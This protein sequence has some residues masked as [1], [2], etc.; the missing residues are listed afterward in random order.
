MASTLIVVESPAKVNTLKKYL[1]SGY[2][3]K[4]SVGHIKDLPKSK[5]GIDVDRDFEPT[6]IIKA[7]RKKTIAELKK[8][9]RS[10]RR[11]LLA[12]DPDREGEAI[13]WHVAEEIG[14]KDKDVY[15]I[16]FGDLTKKTVMEALK[17]PLPLDENKYEAQQTRRI[18]DR[19]VGYQISPVLWEKVRRG[20]SA[21]RVQSVAVR[22]ICERE[23][24]IENFVQE[25]YWS[26]TAR[27]E[28]PEPPFFEAKLKKVDG[29][30][31]PIATE[32]EAEDII[33]ELKKAVFVVNSVENNEVKRQPSPPFTTSK[34]QQEAAQ[35]LRFSAKKTMAV[36]QRLYEGI[37]LGSEGPVGLITYMRTDSVRV[38]DEALNEA[39][40]FISERYGKDYLPARARRHK[41][42]KAAQDAHEA[43]RPSSMRYHPD[44]VKQYLDR[45]EYR[46]YRLIWN[47]FIASQM[48]P[49][50]YDR[51]IVNITAGRYLFSVQGSVMKF[52]G[53]T[54][55]YG[56]SPETESRVG[57]DDNENNAAKADGNLPL[58]S[59][60]DTLTVLA[61]DRKQH[62]TQPPPRFTEASL[63]RELEESGIGRPS[64]YAAIL[65]TIQERNYVKLEDRRFRPT[66]LGRVVTD[67]LVE[68]F[69]GI[70][71]ISFT[72]SMEDKLDGIEEGTLKRVDIL[73]DFYRT[74]SSE[75]EKAKKSMKNM[76]K[77]EEA[78]E[79]E[80]ERCG[81]PMVIKWGKNGRFIACS[82]YPAC[83]NTA[84]IIR[85]DSGRVDRKESE[86]TDIRCEKCGKNMV[87]KEGRFG[88]F[89]GC[90]GYPECSYTRPIDTGVKCPRD[91]C[92]GFLC[93]RRSRRGRVFFGCSEYPDCTF[94]TWDRPLPESC[95]QCG[96]P[97]LV[98]KYSKSKGYFK[99]CPD[100]ECGYRLTLED[101]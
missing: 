37:E 55:V 14:G 64:T 27:L 66:E 10:A 44:T 94:A 35:R 56:D 17:N 77:E 60:G 29:K 101:L 95:P 98:L 91:G 69:P 83:K 65:S 53:F 88:K 51:T 28:G 6:Y 2:D 70:L 18:L 72:A 23:K 4:A 78:T 5:L 38:A 22:I 41:T 58:L 81:S 26:I 87:V 40:S 25:E 11:I 63:V 62:F 36:A 1:G 67:L 59:T 89:L 84:N 79:L 68:S 15:R 99:A 31:V 47:R 82:N 75:L 16:L 50:V 74:F 85:D 20:L 46:L 73:K 52:P 92:K 48:T 9:A 90:S 7:D 54:M 93:E 97:Y 57:G 33:E 45:D 13:A 49:A 43:I 100:R 24:E 71:D 12:P 42:A 86:T 39:R 3:V 32:R 76:K 21:G 30:K 80:C 8:A 61:L 19:L 96:S 34:L